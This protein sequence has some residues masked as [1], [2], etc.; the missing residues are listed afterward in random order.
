VNEGSGRAVK[1]MRMRTVYVCSC[2][3]T[4]R[5]RGGRGVR[6]YEFWVLQDHVERGHKWS[7]EELRKDGLRA[8]V[9]GSG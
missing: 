5:A 1:K 8:A 7:Y 3:E 4:I 2:G 9:G 6:D